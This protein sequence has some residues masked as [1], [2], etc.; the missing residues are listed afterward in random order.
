MML[1]P[2]PPAPP[3]RDNKPEGRSCGEGSLGDAKL[4]RSQRGV[5]GVRGLCPLRFVDPLPPWGGPAEAAS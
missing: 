1:A 2:I 4:C 5:T 3:S